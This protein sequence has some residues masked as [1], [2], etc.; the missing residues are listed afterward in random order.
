MQN[1]FAFFSLV[2]FYLTRAPKRSQ[3]IAKIAIVSSVF[4]DDGPFLLTS[5]DAPGV[6]NVAEQIV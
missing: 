6:I 3:R 2:L 1:F 4:H 5:R